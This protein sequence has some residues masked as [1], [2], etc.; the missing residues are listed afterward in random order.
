VMVEKQSD[1]Y[2]TGGRKVQGGLSLLF[3]RGTSAKVMGLNMHHGSDHHH[4]EEATPCPSP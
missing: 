1:I 4:S 3:S 2:S